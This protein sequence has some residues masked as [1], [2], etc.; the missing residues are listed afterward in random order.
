[1]IKFK[2]FVKAKKDENKEKQTEKDKLPIV[3][4]GFHRDKK[5]KPIGLQEITKEEHKFLYDQN[6]T[7]VKK[8]NKE[9]KA[10]HKMGEHR[11]GVYDYTRGSINVNSHLY[12]NERKRLG[13]PHKKSDL[14]LDE[15]D[16]HTLHHT[17][18]AIKANKMH[19]GI[20][21]HTGL[22]SNPT[23]YFDKG[24]TSTTVRMPAFT[25]TSLSKEVADSFAH[26]K[27]DDK[28]N[29]HKHILSIKIPRG[30]H[31]A[32]VDHIS[33][34]S[35]EHEVILHHGAH[36]KIHHE[37]YKTITHTDDYDGSKHHTHFYHAELVHDGVQK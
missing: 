16:Q 26:Q 22:S 24:K 36:I 13:L 31:A 9:L 27:Y 18:E 37:P 4:A 29:S 6:S 11:P 33:R 20:T 14:H 21:V 1:M 10:K 12:E 25:S 2:D 5:K 30:K 34:H 28:N 19:K 35:G 15:Y 7:E 17:S 32:F 23:K 8:L 3:F